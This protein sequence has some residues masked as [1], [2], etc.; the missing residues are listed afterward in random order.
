MPRRTLKTVSVDFSNTLRNVYDWNELLAAVKKRGTELT[1]S[2]YAPCSQLFDTQ[3]Q[4]LTDSG[5]LYYE[6]LANIL[7]VCQMLLPS[8]INSVLLTVLKI[9]TFSILAF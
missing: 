6:F 8:N 4:L 2:T 1:D 3:K 5:I 9:Q 7:E